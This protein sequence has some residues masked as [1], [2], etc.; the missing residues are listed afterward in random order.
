MALTVKTMH[1]SIRIAALKN[2]FAEAN[3]A[4]DPEKL[5]ENIEEYAHSFSREELRDDK[6]PWIELSLNLDVRYK[7]SEALALH[8]MNLGV[9]LQVKPDSLSKLKLHVTGILEEIDLQEKIHLEKTE[10]KDNK[11]VNAGKDSPDST[12]MGEVTEPVINSRGPNGSSLNARAGVNKAT[13]IPEKTGRK[14]PTLDA[15]IF[16]RHI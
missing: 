7:R 1:V 2:L 6:T 15:Y 10:S 11:E 12:L 16:S 13:V 8:F 14:D 3:A 9:P 4:H 5:L